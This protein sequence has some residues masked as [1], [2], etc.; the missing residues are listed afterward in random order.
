MR[1][2]GAYIACVSVQQDEFYGTPRATHHGAMLE[3]Q[4]IAAML[5]Q[6]QV[7]TESVC[8]CRAD[9]VMT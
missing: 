3:A 1:E 6:K 8:T 7:I 2:E 9:G 5:H 4:E